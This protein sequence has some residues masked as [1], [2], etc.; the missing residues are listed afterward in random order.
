MRKLL[1]ASTAALGLVVSSAAANATLTYTIWN[2]FP[3][4]TP[5]LPH[6]AVFPVPTTGLFATFTDDNNNL[7]FRDNNPEGGSV[8]FNDWCGSTSAHGAQSACSHLTGP[9]LGTTMSTLDTGTNVSTFVEITETY[10]LAAPLVSTLDHDDGA[11][12]YL[13]GAGNGA[14]LC[15]V[16]GEATENTQTCTFPAGTH[17]LTLLYTEDNGSPAILE[18]LLPAEVP[19]PASLALLGSALAGFGVFMRRRRK[20]A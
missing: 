6:S 12:I 14:Q 7:L 4:G 10:N 1:L 9:Q 8:T 15:G 18:V 2:N 11:A 3:G 5:T 16:P 20:A 19:E 17:T 13:D